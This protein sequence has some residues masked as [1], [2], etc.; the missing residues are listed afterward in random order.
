MIPYGHANNGQW[1][2]NRRPYNSNN[3]P[4]GYNNPNGNRYT[5]RPRGEHAPREAEDVNPEQIER[6]TPSGEPV[7]SSPRQQNGY[8]TQ[9]SHRPR[10]NYSS[11]S[12]QASNRGNNRAQRSN[13]YQGQSR[14][15]SQQSHAPYNPD[16]F[17][18]LSPSPQPLQSNVVPTK[19]YSVVAA[20]SASR[21]QS[22]LMTT[23]GSQTFAAKKPVAAKK[24]VQPAAASAP[25]KIPPAK[26]NMAQ[27]E[28][29]L[30]NDLLPGVE[31]IKVSDTSSEEPP[32]NI[33][34]SA[35][36]FS[37]A[38]ALRKA[39]NARKEDSP[40][41]SLVSSKEIRA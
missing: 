16:N 3:M 34:P 38:E 19:A 27:E 8:N 20:E 10:S 32:K 25:K 41:T 22:P 9:N 37:Y 6:R 24:S 40:P 23:N 18:A 29:A 2:Q 12:G 31:S 26:V 17:P 33:S 13:G 5:N 1:R 21:E 11:Q 30:V 39:N 7:G 28:I 35:K 36:T 15:P 14:R 4:Y